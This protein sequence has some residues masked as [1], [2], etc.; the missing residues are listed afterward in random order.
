MRVAR[1]LQIGAVA[2]LGLSSRAAL[3]QSRS[4]V[5]RVTAQVVDVGAL[6]WAPAGGKDG[7]GAAAASSAVVRGG[8]SDRVFSIVPP[9]HSAVAVSMRVE[10]TRAGGSG[11]MAM[12]VCRPTDARRACRQIR[13]A[14]SVQGHNAT[15]IADAAVLVRLTG[16]TSVAEDSTR[17]TVTLAYPDS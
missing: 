9:R 13:L 15:A 5:L 11:G 7:S 12:Q 8:V 16:L 17:V 4:A 1:I 2:V 14:D 3:A 6:S 10:G